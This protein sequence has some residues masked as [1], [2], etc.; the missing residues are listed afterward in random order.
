[1]G[2]TKEAAWRGIYQTSISRRHTIAAVYG[3]DLVSDVVVGQRDANAAEAHGKEAEV[4]IRPHGF[5]TTRLSVDL[6]PVYLTQIS[7]VRHDLSHAIRADRLATADSREIAQVLR[8]KP[9]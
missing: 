5:N 8:E 3:R 4:R 2:G 1:D 9:H 6:L 7:R